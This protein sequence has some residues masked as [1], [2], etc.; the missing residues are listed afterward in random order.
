MSVMV[1]YTL[2]YRG[3]EHRGAHPVPIGPA[4]DFLKP[5]KVS[6]LKETGDLRERF[7]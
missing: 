7:C 3:G 5:D 6:H 4:A 2:M 1:Y